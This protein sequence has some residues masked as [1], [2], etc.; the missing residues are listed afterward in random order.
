MK[1]N[2]Y[3]GEEKILILR[4]AVMAKSVQVGCRENHFSEL[5]LHQWKREF[6]VDQWGIKPNG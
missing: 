1:G 2:R 3:T 4:Q 5:T 6:G